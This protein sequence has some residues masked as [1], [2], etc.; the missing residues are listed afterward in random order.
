MNANFN[1]MIGLVD[2]ENGEPVTTTLQVALGLG[3]M[4][5]SVVKLVRTYMP[6]FQEF[7]RVGFKI[8][9]FETDGGPQERK[10]CDLNEQQATFLLTLMRN[11]PRVIQFKKALVKAFFNAKALL[12][13]D[14][15]SLMQ[16]HSALEATLK[17]E[18]DMASHYG[19]GLNIW[20]K[21][22][23]SLQTAIANI[24]RQLQPCLNFNEGRH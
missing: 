9:S 17:L 22:R 18:Q 5:A 16:Q 14:Y 13:T 6:D 7:G 19:K 15:Y 4:H 20:K 2:V 3:I 10:Y 24:E 11:S 21:K 12:Q 1:P 8:Q 23:D